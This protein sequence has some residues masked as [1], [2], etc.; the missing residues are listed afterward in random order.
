MSGIL[1]GPIGGPK[2]AI[3]VPVRDADIV[4]RVLHRGSR[5]LGKVVGFEDDGVMIEGASGHTRLFRLAPAA[6]VVDNE[7]VTLR[8]P[9]QAGPVSA[10]RRTASGSFMDAKPTP[11]KVAR[12]SRIWVEGIHDAELV[13]KVWGDDLRSVG[14]VVER[15]DGID[16]LPRLVRDFGPNEQ[17]RLGVLVDHLVVGSKEHRL[18]MQ[19]ISDDVLVTGTPFIDVWQ[20]VRPHVLGIKT[21]PVIPRGQDWKS[22]IC[23]HFKVNEPGVLWKKILS[24]VQSFTDL[25]ASFVGAVE[26]LID[27]V[28]EFQ[29]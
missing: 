24:S 11:A 22:G 21:W 27:H 20:A 16:D 6:F 28:T 8:R 15:L 10:M 29:Q 17:R 26:E 25:E 5:F 3:Q 19:V 7:V 2:K 4:L 13:E 18:A 1:G 23:A 14:V 12:A 9:R